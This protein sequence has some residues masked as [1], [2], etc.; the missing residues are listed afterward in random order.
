MSLGPAG[1][2][3]TAR[4]TQEVVFSGTV[5]RSVLIEPLPAECLTSPW[6]QAADSVKEMGPQHKP[7]G[8]LAYDPVEEWSKS[9]ENP[10][11][12]ASLEPR[13]EGDQV[14][15]QRSEGGEE[16][17]EGVCAHGWHRGSEDVPRPQGQ[18]DLRT[19][20]AQRQCED[21]AFTPNMGIPWQVRD[22]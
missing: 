13:C 20:G 12:I 3:E 19:Y 11:G 17:P 18:K 21:S 16:L 10:P 14:T 2:E 22:Q 6:R 8:N 1:R 5:H 9:E 15:R 7:Q 4:S